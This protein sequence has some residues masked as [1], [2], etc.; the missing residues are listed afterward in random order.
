MDENQQMTTAAGGNGVEARALEF[1][2]GIASRFRAMEPQAR[3]RLGIAGA[4]LLACLLGLG[5]YASRTD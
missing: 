3:K 1:A 4:I 2:S 5:W